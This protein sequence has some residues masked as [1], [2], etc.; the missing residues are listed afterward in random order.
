MVGFNWLP[1]LLLVLIPLALLLLG[2]VALILLAT[3]GSRARRL[4]GEPTI[5]ERSPLDIARERYARGEI[6][7][8]E[9]EQIRRDLET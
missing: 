8:E 7:R 6:T 5:V 2:I 4:P 9:F 3:R 1:M